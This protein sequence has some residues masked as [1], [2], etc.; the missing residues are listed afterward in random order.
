MAEL[1]DLP[2]EIL[3]RTALSLNLE[4]LSDFCQ[5]SKLHSDFCHDRIFINIWLKWNHPELIELFKEYL[6]FH[7]ELSFLE[8]ISN[9]L[10]HVE[11]GE[12]IIP[13]SYLKFGHNRLF[14]MAGR[15]GDEELFRFYIATLGYEESILSDFIEGLLEGSL[16]LG[17]ATYL[18]DRNPSIVRASDLRILPLDKLK[19]NQKIRFDLAEKYITKIKEKYFALS[20]NDEDEKEE[21][22][23]TL[24]EIQL[25]KY[26]LKLVRMETI[27]PELGYF[28]ELPLIEFLGGGNVHNSS[29]LATSVARNVAKYQGAAHKPSDFPV[30]EA[31][32]VQNFEIQIFIALLLN[33]PSLAHDYYTNHADLLKVG[34]SIE[35]FISSIGISQYTYRKN[36]IDFTRAEYFN[37][38]AY[39]KCTFLNG[40]LISYNT[41]KENGN[42]SL[43]TSALMGGDSLLISTLFH[44]KLINNKDLQGSEVYLFISDISSILALGFKR[45][46]S[47]LRNIEIKNRLK[48]FLHRYILAMNRIPDDI[49][50]NYR[51]ISLIFENITNIKQ[52]ISDWITVIE[53]GMLEFPPQDESELQYL[54]TPAKIIKFLDLAGLNLV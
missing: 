21:M 19:L 54:L 31:D 15:Q 4:E 52:I 42:I 7:P 24:N 8:I 40:Q 1:S 16:I 9:L 48:A 47:L 45:M 41:I 25:V 6:D 11:A 2:N 12:L 20:I 3:Q 27:S 38:N 14:R 35:S 5:T 51:V 53:L 46:N 43:F 32:Q 37:P 10:E 18:A 34:L 28:E 36:L 44:G 13:D 33:Y 49:V 17:T 39:M 30:L 50:P 22:E 26:A 23:S 29:S